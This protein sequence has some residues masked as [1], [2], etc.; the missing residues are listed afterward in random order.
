MLYL[1]C[2]ITDLWS[3]PALQKG[4]M[5]YLQ[6]AITDRC[7]VLELQKGDILYLQCVIT[8]FW[9]VPA[10]QKG[11]MLYLHCAITD[12]WSVLALPK[13]ARI[14]F[15]HCTMPV[16]LALSLQTEGS[17][18]CLHRISSADHALPFDPWCTWHV[19]TSFSLHA[20]HYRFS[21]ARH[22]KTFV[23]ACPIHSLEPTAYYFCWKGFPGPFSLVSVDLSFCLV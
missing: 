10:F 9:S 1:H 17:V 5:L 20:Q 3:V 21:W 18:A 2:A 6:C 13:R 8:D 19:A 4:D 16:S 14:R 7:S 15:L 23:G 22:E 11:D 12:L